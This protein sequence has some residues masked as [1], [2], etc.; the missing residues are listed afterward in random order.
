M[1]YKNATLERF[2]LFGYFCLS[3]SFL[4]KTVS[5]QFLLVYLRKKVSENTNMPAFILDEIT[6]VSV[7]D[8]RQLNSE[9][10]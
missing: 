10:T 4:E 8:S 9:V 6:Y 3:F 7:A 1:P 5:S 2:L